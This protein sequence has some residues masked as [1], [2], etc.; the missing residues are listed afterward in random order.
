[1]TDQPLPSPQP[2]PVRI[3]PADPGFRA[4]VRTGDEQA[5]RGFT[6]PADLAALLAATKPALPLHPAP[7]TERPTGE[8]N[9]NLDTDP[10]SPP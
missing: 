1:M 5:P 6:A 7:G 8:N 3:W 9:A 10:R 4:S 2:H